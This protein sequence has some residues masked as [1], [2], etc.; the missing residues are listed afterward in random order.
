MEAINRRVEPSGLLRMAAPVVFGSTY[1]APTIADFISRYPRIEVELK[2]SDR[3]I[4][5]I[6]DGFDLAVRI[7]LLGSSARP[8]SA[9]H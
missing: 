9:S 5:V 6:G 7:R 3:P 4:D 1:I 2:A 8:S